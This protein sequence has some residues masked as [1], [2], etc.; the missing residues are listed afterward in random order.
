MKVILISG[1]AQHG[2]TSTAI[3]LE[4][5]MK[6]AGYRALHINFADYVK[7]VCSRYFGW[8]GKK[9]EQGRHILQYVG[10]DIFRAR[11]ENFWVDTIIRFA[12][13]TWTDYDFMLVADWRFPNEF[14]RWG[15]SGIDG[16]LKVRVYR[17]GF[18]SGLTEEQKNHP[19]ETALDSFPMDYKLHAVDLTGL[20]AECYKVLEGLGIKV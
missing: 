15:E 1:K 9:D 17:P 20:E 8:D 3:I 14:T 11:D 18:D 7:F 5:H 2:K 10:T 12:R 16:V 4:K 13:A 6:R 19:S